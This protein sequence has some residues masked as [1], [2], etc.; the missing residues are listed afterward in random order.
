MGYPHPRGT[1]SGFGRGSRGRWLTGFKAEGGLGGKGRGR[2]RYRR[3]SWG[4][5]NLGDGGRTFSSCNTLGLPHL[6]DH[7]W[8]L[9]VR[10][11]SEVAALGRRKGTVGYELCMV[12][13]VEKK[14][15]KERKKRLEIG[16][17]RN[18]QR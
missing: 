14:G 9:A 10:R 12:K 7:L 2:G 17:S 6:T 8:E 15:R 13:V 5:L 3:G 11:G 16:K 4:F 18:R 1:L